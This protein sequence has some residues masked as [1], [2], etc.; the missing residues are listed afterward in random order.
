MAIGVLHDLVSTLTEEFE[1]FRLSRFD[2][3]EITICR[4]CIL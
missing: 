4:D 1:A 2:G 3:T